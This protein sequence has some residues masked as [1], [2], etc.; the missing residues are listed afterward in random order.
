MLRFGLSVVQSSAMVPNLRSLVNELVANEYSGLC[1][2][3]R[4]LTPSDVTIYLTAE[5][6]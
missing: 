6:L 1:S 4:A 3:D 2:G 5:L